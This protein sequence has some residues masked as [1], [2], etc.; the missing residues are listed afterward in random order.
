MN[1]KRIILMTRLAAFEQKHKRQ[2]QEAG[3]YY[4]S[5]YIGI[6][7]L[8][9]FFRMTVVYLI[10][11]IFWC[12]YHLEELMEKLNTMDLKGTIR[13]IVIVY[14]LLMSVYLLI[15]Y[16]IGTL[17]FYR[18]TKIRQTYRNMLGHLLMEYDC[19]KP[20]RTRRREKKR[21]HGGTD[22]DTTVEL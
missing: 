4:R 8:K 12:C 5:D 11:L 14:V 6:Q 20:V 15:T 2:L 17:R 7:L 3:G 16:V 13:G 22:Y 21:K 10:C 1:E 19:E 9:N 18:S